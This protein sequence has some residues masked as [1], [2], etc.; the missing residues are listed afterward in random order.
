MAYEV[1][2]AS[3]NKSRMQ[4]E[5]ATTRIYIY[6]CVCVC[7]YIYIYIYS[8]QIHLEEGREYVETMNRGNRERVTKNE[9]SWSGSVGLFIG[10]IVP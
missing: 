4:N 7:V 10:R 1:E 3:L 9:G 2:M 6:I 5:I 8:L